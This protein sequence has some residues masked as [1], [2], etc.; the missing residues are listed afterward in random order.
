VAIPV[1]M[2]SSAVGVA[3]LLNAALGKNVCAKS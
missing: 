1:N 3:D 2:C